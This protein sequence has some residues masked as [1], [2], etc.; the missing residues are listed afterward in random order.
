MDAPLQICRRFRYEHTFYTNTHKK[1]CK[2]Y[3]LLFI[4]VVYNI[5][6]KKRRI[7]MEYG[8]LLDIAFNFN[9]YQ[10]IGTCDKT[11]RDATGCRCFDGRYRVGPR[12]FENCS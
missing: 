4:V 8:Y 5:R 2:I 6:G 7:V 1:R 9:F 3:N 10:S 11:Y 12:L